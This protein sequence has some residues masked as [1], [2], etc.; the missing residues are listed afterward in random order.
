[1]QKNCTLLCPKRDKKYHI[2]ANEFRLIHL[3]PSNKVVNQSTNTVTFKFV[4]ESCIYYLNELSILFA[5]TKMGKKCF[6]ALV[7]WNSLLESSKEHNV[8][9]RLSES[10]YEKMTVLLLLP[11]GL[12]VFTDEVYFLI[13][14]LFSVSL[15]V[16]IFFCFLHPPTKKLQ[17]C[18]QKYIFL[19]VLTHNMFFNIYFPWFLFLYRHLTFILSFFLLFLLEE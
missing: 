17:K 13:F 11:Q 3:L 14:L 5:K 10:N 7:P 6:H 8:K 15:F 12:T 16:L 1:M 9:N 4:N 19:T 18:L 2:P